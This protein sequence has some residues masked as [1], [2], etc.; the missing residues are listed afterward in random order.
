[1]GVIVCGEN[2]IA[3]ADE[4]NAEVCIHCGQCVAACPAGAI[5]LE[6]PTDAELLEELA[7]Y[8]IDPLPA[9]PGDQEPA[10]PGPFPTPEQFD[11]LVRARR[12]IRDYRV[13]PVGHDVIEHLVH[14]VLTFA[15]TGHNIRGLKTVVVE[16]RERIDQLTDLSIPYFAQLAQDPS[17][18]SFD[19]KV[20]ARI[21]S[22]WRANR[23]DRVFRTGHQAMFTYCSTSIPP[24]E[25]AVLLNLAYFQLAALTRGIGTAWAGYFMIVANE[26]PIKQF[27]GVSPGESIHGAVI[28]GY[29][30]WSF[31]RTPARPDIPLR[32]LSAHQEENR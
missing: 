22:A 19:R 1:M 25:P 9:R 2:G 32:Y 27:L 3:G 8:G 26:P 10:E 16:G 11:S 15:P 4:T 20:F 31:P 13:E 29:P 28:F 17:C 7:D 18:H 14:Q 30:R 23:I 24:R 21:V 12:T 5:S 6:A